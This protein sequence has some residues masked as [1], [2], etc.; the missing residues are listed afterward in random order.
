M[1][2]I[3]AYRGAKQELIPVEEARSVT[4]YRCPWTKQLFPTK[5][6]Y[7]KHL[8]HLRE[9][10][11]RRNARVLAC[12]RAMEDFFNQP[13]LQDL[14]DWVEN[15][16][17]VLWDRAMICG[18][19]YLEK[20]ARR[21]DFWIKITY[22]DVQYSNTV[23]NTHSAPKGKKT[24][25]GGRN[26]DVPRGYPGYEGRIEF[27]VSSRFSG[28]GSSFFSNVLRLNTGTGGGT[29]ENRFGFGVRIF[30]DDFPG[31]FKQRSMDVLADR[32]TTGITTGKA[33]YFDW[34]R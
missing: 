3:K 33:H 21:E 18:S 34:S 24:N 29:S 27:Q 10:R 8:S 25:W 15:N 26:P 12:N 32:R 14:V 7:T 4:A 1:P 9:T 31:L 5:G 19:T 23:S 16:P 2:A 6:K 13:T 28:F 11:M 20:N 22:L 17:G 30:L